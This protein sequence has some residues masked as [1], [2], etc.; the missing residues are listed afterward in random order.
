MGLCT[1]RALAAGGRCAPTPLF[2]ASPSAQGLALTDTAWGCVAC[3]SA[4]V[5]QHLLVKKLS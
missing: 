4:A 3:G 1:H 2:L 5:V